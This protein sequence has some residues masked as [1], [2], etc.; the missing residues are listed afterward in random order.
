MKIL[1]SSDL[2]G[3]TEAYKRYASLLKEY[4]IGILSGDLY[5][6]FRLDEFEQIRRKYGIA[7]DDLLEELHSPED[8]L[9][10]QPNEKLALAFREK[11]E[12]YKDIL[13]GA[14]KPIYFIMGNDDG[15][16]GHEWKSTK[17]IININQKR[18]DLEEWNLVG[19][20]YTNPFVGGLFE[21]NERE[22]QRDMKELSLLVDARTILVTHGPAFGMHDHIQEKSINGI[23]HYG[24]KA[25]AV[26]IKNRQPQYHLYGHIHSEFGIYGKSI[27]G[28]YPYNKKF[29]AIDLER[30]N[31]KW[32]E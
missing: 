30:Q 9:P 26:L 25:L 15:I 27:N 32:V 5:T 16:V 24:S 29:V 11:E 14:S 10:I 31:A 12:E 23:K 4:D 22:Q 2:H 18:V 1:F 20:Q 13:S 19:Y 21:K 7:R 8:N 6:G 28:A 3:S 17:S